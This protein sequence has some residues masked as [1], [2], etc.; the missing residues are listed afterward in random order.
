[1]R[2]CVVNLGCKVN[3]VESDSYEAAFAAAGWQQGQPEEADAII[4]NTCIVTGEAEKK[5]R[6]AVR[7]ALRA[8]PRARVLATGCAAAVAPD[9]LCALDERVEVVAKADMDLAL[10]T[11]TAQ[12]SAPACTLAPERMRAGVKVQDGCD[13]ACTFCIVH[14]ARGRTRSMPWQRVQEECCDLARRGLREVVLTGINLATYHDDGMRLAGLLERLLSAT[15]ELC[16]A[17]GRAC[18]FR[19]S[20][21][22]P[23]D[24]DD[25]LIELLAAAEGRVCRHLHLPLQSGSSAV[26]RQMARPYDAERFLDLVARLRAAV[27]TISLTTDII[28]GFPGESAADH[29]Q[30]MQVAR[31]ARFSKMHV[32]PYSPRAGTPAASRADQ[33][34][35]EVKAL[36]ASE[37]RALSEELRATDYRSRCGTRERCVVES[38]GRARTESYHEVRADAAAQPGSFADVLLTAEAR[39]PAGRA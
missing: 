6:K 26:L 7:A 5:T 37:L 27:P 15:G 35:S 24:V 3:R 30:S 19:I 1:M 38:A 11:M 25:A 32:F 12:A 8:N 31:A 29:A 2:F 21:V 34:P 36:R 28:A 16:D 23:A 33:V 10:A 17:Q 20:S 13:N 18:R 14:V 4:V 9:A 39:L 22:E